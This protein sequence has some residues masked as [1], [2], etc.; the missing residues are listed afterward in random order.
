[1]LPSFSSSFSTLPYHLSSP[2]PHFSLPSLFL[3]T[4]SSAGRG[5]FKIKI[6]SENQQHIQ[7]TRNSFHNTDGNTQPRTRSFHSC[8]QD[9]R[10]ELYSL[11][12][13]LSPFPVQKELPQ[14][15]Y[16]LGTE[17]FFQNEWLLVDATSIVIVCLT[18]IHLLFLELVVSDDIANH[19]CVH[20]RCYLRE[21]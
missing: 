2:L 16:D 18:F 1:M 7:Y 14:L 15:R 6:I 10:Q 8:F 19:I 4:K 20:R 21:L 17:L 5:L 11:W 13:G 12:E 9:R 3:F